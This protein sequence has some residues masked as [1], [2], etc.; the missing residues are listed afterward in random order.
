MK[1][2]EKYKVIL[3]DFDGVI[4]DSM[5]VRELGFRE[6]LKEYP[7]DQLEKLIHF[8]RING[9]WSRYVKFRYF[10]EEIRN[11][12]V[13]DEQIAV[14][15]RKFSEIMRK[16][17]VSEELLICDSLN[18]IK[19]NYQDQP[20]HVVSGSDGEELRYL[21]RQLGLSKYF[22]SIHGSPTPK[23]TLIKELLESEKYSHEEVIMIGDAHNDREASF[24]NRI[25]F[26]GYNNESLRSPEYIY[27]DSFKVLIHTS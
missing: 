21:C 20:M 15:S 24:A 11:E 16:N 14:L 25:A 12:E 17:L 18:Y 8:H 9:G 13:S 5:P 26:A 3:W 1:D 6:V 22:V 4:M 2:L 10:Y 27:I 7:D 23:A 19:E